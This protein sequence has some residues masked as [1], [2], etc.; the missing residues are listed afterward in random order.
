MSLS[1]DVSEKIFF[2]VN[3]KIRIREIT[4]IYRT[5]LSFKREI[6]YPIKKKP[7][8]FP[9]LFQIQTVNQCNGSCLMCPNKKIKSKKPEKMSDELFKKIIQEI[10]KESKT[11]LVLL[12]LQNEPLIDDELFQKIKLIKKLSNG[13]IAT[14]FIT[15][16]VLFNFR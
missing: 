8:Y 4:N 16:G 10:V 3:N 2:I 11:T 7:Y 13:V 12:Y 14:S 1:K 5:I 9:Y 15:N 6:E